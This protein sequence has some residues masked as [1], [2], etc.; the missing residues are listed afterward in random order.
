MKIRD[1]SLKGVRVQVWDI[2][3]EDKCKSKS[4]T[5]YDSNVLEIFNR[6]F[7]LFGELEKAEDGV[8]IYHH[9]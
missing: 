8:R 2:S 6:I 3:K 1:K 7:L 4:L 9:K 5:I